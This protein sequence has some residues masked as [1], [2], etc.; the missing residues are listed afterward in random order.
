MGFIMAQKLIQPDQVD[1]LNQN[2]TGSAATL[3][4]SRNINGVAFNGSADITVTAA[5]GTLTGATL[6]AGVT[7]SSLTSVGALTGV[8]V[9]GNLV[10][11]STARRITGDMTNA[12]VSNRVAFQTS[13]TNGN[14]LLE[15]LPNGSATTAQISTSNAADPTNSYTGQFFTSSTFVTVTGAVRGSGTAL[16]MQITNNGLGCILL[17]TA[18]NITFGPQASALATNATDRFIYIQTM[19]GTPSGT[20]TAIT[21][22]VPMVYDTTNN[23]LYVYNGG[24]KSA[25]FA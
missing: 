21:G 9:D 11:N 25:T 3:T 13:T 6:A 20:P 18:G 19:A 2:T 10:F 12:T 14:T 23:K 8:T 22:H 24:W 5:A 7:G 17:S 15:I 16:P 1:T 4:T